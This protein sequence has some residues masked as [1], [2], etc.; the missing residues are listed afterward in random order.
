[1]RGVI[2]G[3]LAANWQPVDYIVV[4]LFIIIFP[5]V[6]VYLI[7]KT[8]PV[9]KHIYKVG[10]FRAVIIAFLSFSISLLMG[11]LCILPLMKGYIKL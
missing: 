8:V 10:R 6:G 11:N 1:M 5:M 7:V 2:T 4:L 3:E 9:I